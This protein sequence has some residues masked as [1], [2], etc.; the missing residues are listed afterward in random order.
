MAKHSICHVEWSSTDLNRSKTFYGGLFDWKF[1]QW[2]ETYALFSAPDG[3]GGGISK[4]DR[5]APTDATVVYIM[6]DEIAPYLGRAA[7]LGGGVAVPKT[8][9]P[10]MGWFAHLKDPDGNVVGIYQNNHK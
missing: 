10:N 8:E 5:V 6:V 4:V 7:E 1:E 3:A 9:I 2:N